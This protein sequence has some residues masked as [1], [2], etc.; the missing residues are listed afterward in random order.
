MSDGGNW[1]EVDWHCE[2]S[3]AP[4]TPA[5]PPTSAALPPLLQGDTN[6]RYFEII[7][8]PPYCQFLSLF[9]STVSQRGMGV[10]PKRCVDY[11]QCEVMRFYKVENKGSIVPL[12]MTV[13]RKV[14]V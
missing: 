10:L 5:A 9:Q 7:A 14:C 13:P 2:V 12:I 6:I 3:A 1:T 11:K 4:P 8:E